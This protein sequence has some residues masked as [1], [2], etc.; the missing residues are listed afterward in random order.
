MC[1]SVAQNC[2]GGFTLKGG[3]GAGG[4]SEPAS[5]AMML[6]GFGGLGFALRRRR[7]LQETAAG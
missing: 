5:W 4:V 2:G 6:V 7:A 3:G 1:T